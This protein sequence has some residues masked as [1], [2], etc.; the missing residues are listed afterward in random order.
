MAITVHNE[1]SNVWS[2]LRIKSWRSYAAMGII[3]HHEKSPYEMSLYPHDAWLF[4]ILPGLVMTKTLCELEHG[5]FSSLIDL[6]KMV[7]F[8]S[9]LYVYQRL[10]SNVSFMACPPGP[11]GSA[12]HGLRRRCVV[13]F[14]GSRTTASTSAGVGRLVATKEWWFSGLMLICKRV[15]DG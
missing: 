1:N 4:F 14:S 7:I 8:H 9:F 2:P 5:T 10:P 15:I 3:A 12:S 6:W 13:C 11:Q